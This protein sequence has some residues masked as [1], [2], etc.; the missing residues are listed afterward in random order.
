[1]PVICYIIFPVHCI[2]DDI[3]HILIGFGVLDLSRFTGPGEIFKA[4]DGVS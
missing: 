3:T 4:M 2:R 1:M